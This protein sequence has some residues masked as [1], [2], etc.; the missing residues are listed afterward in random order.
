[1]SIPWYVQERAENLYFGMKLDTEGSQDKYANVIDLCLRDAEGKDEAV[2]LSAIYNCAQTDSNDELI[3]H[4][5]RATAY[6]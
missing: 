3:Q 6:Q 5:K 1:M 4:L 2:F